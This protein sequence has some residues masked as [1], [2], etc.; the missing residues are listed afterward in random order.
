MRKNV[1][2]IVAARRR[3]DNIDVAT[4]KS[5]GIEVILLPARTLAVAEYVIGAAMI[6]AA[7]SLCF[8]ECRREWK[9]A[10][11]CFSNGRETAGKTLV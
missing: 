6:F 4:R 9:V 7:R 1:K 11:Q 3:A 2:V 10:A 8:V 5:R